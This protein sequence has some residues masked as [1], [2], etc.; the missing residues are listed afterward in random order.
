MKRNTC[1]SCHFVQRTIDGQWLCRAE[2]PK[3]LPVQG[4]MGQIGIASA[5]PPVQPDRDFCGRHPEYVRPGLVEGAK[6]AN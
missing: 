1:S 6:D 4:A 5:W 2:P 3:I